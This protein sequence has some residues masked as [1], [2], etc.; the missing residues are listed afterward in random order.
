[1]I[2]ESTIDSNKEKFLE[3]NKSYNIFTDNLLDFLG[4]NFFIAPAS[5]STS[6]YYCYPGGLLSFL[7]RV[8]KYAVE[9][10]EKMPESV[11]LD[12]KTVIRT[13]FLSQIG[14]TFLFKFNNNEWMAKNKGRIYEY[15]DDDIVI[16]N[17][18][19]RSAYYALKY[20]VDL[21]EEEYQTILNLDKD[22]NERFMRGSRP[23]YY[24]IKT[25]IEFAL[26]EEKYEQKTN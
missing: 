7:M 26:I 12:K 19:E 18:G 14:K 2:S 11:K 22:S 21:S 17:V 20:G 10:N 25:G 8:A 13:S 16:M 24:V 3:I 1:M 5:V 6:M 15:K 4:D 9:V 23:L